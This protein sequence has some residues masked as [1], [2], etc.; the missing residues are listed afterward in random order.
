KPDPTTKK[1]ITDYPAPRDLS[2]VRTFLG[3]TGHYRQFIQGY[4]LVAAPMHELTK[5]SVAWKWDAPQQEAF[6]KLKDIMTSAPVLKLPDFTRE[7]KFTLQTDASDQGLGA[8]LCQEDTDGKMHPVAFA[9][10]RLTDAELKYHTQEKEALAIIWACEKFRPYLMSE[11][12]DV[13][14]DHGSLKWLLGTQKGRLARWAMR[15]S[16]FDLKI[17]PKPGKLNGNADAPS[18]FPVDDAD[19]DWTPEG[20]A[21]YY[22]DLLPDQVSNIFLCNTSTDAACAR[23]RVS[24]IA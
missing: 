1:A 6:Q 14:T 24:S 5:P 8:V 15:L 23:V 10:R 16:E 4:A 3:M 19:M 20:S 21:P 12:F 17:K 2:S 11:T 9:S 13:E 18:R 7:F 22:T